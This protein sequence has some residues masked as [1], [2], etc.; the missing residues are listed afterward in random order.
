MFE[1]RLSDTAFFVSES[2]SRRQ[3]IS[4]DRFAFH[5]NPKKWRSEIR[6]V[7]ESF[8]AEVY[9]L[10][11]I[12][13]S[14]RSHYFLDGLRNTTLVQIRF[15]ATGIWWLTEEAEAAVV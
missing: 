15:G 3:D 14:L 12:T 4:L 9:S 6:S 8:A 10:D 1:Y 11:D 7:W 5:W 13:V 2:K